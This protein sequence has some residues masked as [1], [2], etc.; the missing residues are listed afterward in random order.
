MRLRCPQVHSPLSA[1]G[2]I[3][4]VVTM[5]LATGR[6]EGTLLLFGRAVGDQRP[7]FVIQ[8]G[9]HDLRHRPLPPPGALV[10]VG[11]DLAAEEAEV[12]AMLAYGLGGQL[13]TQ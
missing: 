4:F 7:S 9:E 2:P 13:R 3:V 10:P 6:V 5:E 12:V 11:D 1:A 8:S